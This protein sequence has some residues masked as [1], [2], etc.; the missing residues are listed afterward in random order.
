MNERRVTISE[1]RSSAQLSFFH[2]L[3][4][5]AQPEGQIS[6]RTGHCM[7]TLLQTSGLTVI[8][9]HAMQRLLSG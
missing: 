5:S 9:L 2:S 4:G 8:T 6:Y 3:M 7:D 1:S